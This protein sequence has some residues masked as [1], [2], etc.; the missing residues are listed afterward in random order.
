VALSF[1]DYF[2][3]ENRKARRFA[4]LSSETIHFIAELERVTSAP[5]SLICDDPP[6][7]WRSHGL[8]GGSAAWTT[9]PMAG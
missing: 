2:T 1:A 7:A 6:P 3:V 5:V 9:T 4:Q 8:A